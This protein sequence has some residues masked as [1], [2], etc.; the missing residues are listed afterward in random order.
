[1]IQLPTHIHPDQ[2]VLDELQTYQ[3]QIVGTF[4]EKQTLAKSKF[5]SRNKKGNR[6]FD[7]I[8]E[9]LT[10]MCS[11]ARR[12]AYCEDAPAD[13][14]EHFFPKILYPDKCFD[15]NNYLYA[16]GPCN[17]PKSSQFAIFEEITGILTILDAT[18]PPLNGQPV[19]INPRLEN[20]M[21]FCRLNLHTFDFEIIEPVGTKDYIRADYTFNTVLRLN[22]QREPLR[23]AREIAYGNYHGRLFRYAELKATALPIQLDKMV[24]QLKRESHPTVWKEIQRSHQEGRLAHLDPDFDALFV[25]C[26]EA[27]HW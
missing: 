3:N 17:G 25:K 18:E 9:K 10:L 11:G 22:T 6:V 27:L 24:V 13:E 20:G 2:S 23:E 7:N 12:C 19:L 16:C 4:S 14:V 21:D 15:W 5:K 26:P 1:M 8:K